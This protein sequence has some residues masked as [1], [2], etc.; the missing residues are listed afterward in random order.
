[1]VRSSSLYSRLS[2]LELLILKLAFQLLGFGHFPHRF[3]E[4][5]LIDGIALVFDG[6]QSPVSNMCC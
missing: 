5:I 3:I 4:V 1:M 6:K 2:G